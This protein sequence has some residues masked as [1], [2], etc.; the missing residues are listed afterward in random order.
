MRKGEKGIAILAPIV[1]RFK[2]ED[3]ESGE[4]RTIESAPRSFRVVHVFALEQTDG[5][6]LPEIP[7]HR[8]QGDGAACQELVA[9]ALSC[10][11][12]V[13]VDELPGE[14]NGLC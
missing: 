13:T 6:D 4:E 12:R 7:C 11:F 3:A 2:V 8:L 10:G 14:I 1:R 9:Y 5:D